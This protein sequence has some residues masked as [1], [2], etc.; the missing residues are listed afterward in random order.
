[1][2]SA[3]EK[4]D[5]C[6]FVDQ[7]GI[8]QTDNA[9]VIATNNARSGTYTIDTN[10]TVTTTGS[11]GAVYNGALSVDSKCSCL[12]LSL[13]VKTPRRLSVFANRIAFMHESIKNGER[14]SH[15]AESDCLHRFECPV[16]G[17]A[18]DIR[19]KKRTLMSVMNIRL[20]VHINR[21]R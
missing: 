4:T 6:H 21:R 7:F 12:P 5:I 8:A 11:D 3:Q 1:M 20:I 15:A 2:T 16:P 18:N 17:S 14:N 13:L 10:G 9:G 19:R